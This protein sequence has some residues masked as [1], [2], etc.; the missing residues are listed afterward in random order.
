MN[1]QIAFFTDKGKRAVNEDSILSFYCK[2]VMVAVV[3]DGL[4]GHGGGDEASRIVVET[5]RECFSLLPEMTM[6]NIKN[7]M[8]AANNNVL[9]L[10]QDGGQMKATVVAAFV[11]GNKVIVAHAGDSRFYVLGKKKVLYESKDH[12]VS[13]M[14]VEMGMIKKEELRTSPDRNKVFRV[15][16]SEGYRIEIHEVDMPSKAKV[17]ILCSD[18][19]WQ[20]VTEDEMLECLNRNTDVEEYVADMIRILQGKQDERQDNYSVIAIGCEK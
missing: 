4:G 16:G 3:S 9:H 5:I 18:G 15:M 6:D 7:I 14:A 13:Q 17:M 20:N 2:D 12:S 11:S 1:K 8:D 19:F 10:Q